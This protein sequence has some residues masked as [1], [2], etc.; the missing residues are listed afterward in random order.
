MPLCVCGKQRT[1]LTTPFSCVGSGDETQ[2]LWPS[3]RH[4]TQCYLAIPLS[5]GSTKR[6]DVPSN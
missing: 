5:G 2:A 6:M 3:S 1:I 4:C